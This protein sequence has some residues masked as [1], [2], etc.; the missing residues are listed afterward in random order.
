VETGLQLSRSR[1]DAAVQA[2]IATETK[3][4]Q[5][6]EEAQ[7]GVERVKSLEG[8]KR[9]LLQ[10]IADMQTQGKK[11]QGEEATVQTSLRSA[12]TSLEEARA[13]LLSQ[14][15]SGPKGR[16]K[17]LDQLT[18]AA[19][20]GGPLE[21]A[22]L[23]GRLGDLATISPEYDVA[24]STCCA[25]LDY[26]VVDTTEGGQACINYLRERNIGRANF[27]VL[28]QLGQHKAGIERS[29]KTAV[30]AGAK[31]VLDL[32]IPS[33]PTLIPA[34]YMALRDTLVASD[35]ESAVAIA[36]QVFIT[37]TN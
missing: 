12:V 11:C 2:V 7:R 8:E 29:Q 6:R 36:Y 21:Q 37:I 25:M 1:S 32:V 3:I 16:N 14:Q 15:Q 9:E 33:S 26:L 13:A 35:L 17:E 19:K 28:D 27:I 23:W 30:P 34:F 31:R 5:L 18:A 24:I 22:G 20:K 10:Q 4:S